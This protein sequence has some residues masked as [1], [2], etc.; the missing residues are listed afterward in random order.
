M[1]EIYI[2]RHAEKET[3]GENSPL[4]AVGI[5]QSEVTAEE[6]ENR[7]ISSIYSSPSRRA[8]HTSEI[9]A[10]RLGLQVIPDSRLRERLAWG[11]RKDE[12]YEQF[13][14]EWRK[15]QANKYYQPTYGGDSRLISGNRVK[16]VVDEVGEATNDALLLVT[17]SG[18]IGDFLE[19]V[20]PDEFL[21]FYIEPVAKVRMVEIL[22]CSI[23]VIEANKG[24]YTLKKVNDTSHLSA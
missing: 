23:T 6:L 19:T 17:H 24:R 9:I 11:D 14:E 13:L 16:Q 18:A 7:G 22:Y 3:R 4:N 10:A 21:P 8:F 5:K 1:A 15:T 2:V 20:F 12:T